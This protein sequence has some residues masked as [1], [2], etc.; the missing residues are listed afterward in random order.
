[1]GL[2]IMDICPKI[3]RGRLGAATLGLLLA[4]WPYGPAAGS[5]HGASLEYQLKAAFLLNFTRYVEWPRKSVGTGDLNLC[6]VGPDVFGTTL[7]ELAANKVVNGRRLA[8]RKNVPAQEAANCD[9]VYLSLTETSQIRPALKTLASSSALTVGE[10][11]GFVRMGGMIAF[12]PQ[13]GKLRFYINAG[14]AE[15]AGITISS[16][17]MVLAKNLHDEGERHR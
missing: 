11:A 12:S 7:D 2:T 14:A 4:A 6:V 16:R 1:M 15:H 9:V 3:R 17:L 13:D 5:A 10:E 8:I